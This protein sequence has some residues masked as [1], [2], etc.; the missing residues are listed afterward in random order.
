MSSRTWMNRSD[1]QVFAIAP[2]VLRALRPPS[3]WRGRDGGGYQLLTDRS[4]GQGEQVAKVA[5][6]QFGQ[7]ALA[8]GDDEVGE[9][10]FLLDHFIDFL[11]EG[12]GADELVY[13]H[14]AFLADPERAVGRLVFHGR[15]PPP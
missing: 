2:R 3:T 10:L 15:V 5:G 13:L 14:R 1:H 8:V 9:R 6:G 4:F 12:A 7:P 11:F